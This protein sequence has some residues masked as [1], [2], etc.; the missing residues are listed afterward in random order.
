MLLIAFDQ[1]AQL[2]YDNVDLYYQTCIIVSCGFISRIT[3]FIIVWHI[4]SYL[5]IYNTM[6]ALLRH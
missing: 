5:E 4:H 1:C 3:A 6:S 2:L